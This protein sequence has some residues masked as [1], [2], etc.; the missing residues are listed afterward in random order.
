MEDDDDIKL[1]T[2]LLYICTYTCTV[3]FKSWE[4]SLMMKKVSRMWNVM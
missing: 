2:I 4:Y 1:L 3:Y